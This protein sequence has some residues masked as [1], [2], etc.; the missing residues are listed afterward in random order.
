[1]LYLNSDLVLVFHNI[2]KLHLIAHLEFYYLILN[3][4]PRMHVGSLKNGYPQSYSAPIDP[5]QP[6]VNACVA[7]LL[8]NL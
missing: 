2:S 5:I 4:A 3:L 8:N 6:E 7:F 1:M